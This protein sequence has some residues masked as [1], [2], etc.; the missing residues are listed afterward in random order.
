MR[1]SCETAPVKVNGTPLPDV[2]QGEIADPAI[3]ETVPTL[4]GKSV[5]DG[6]AIT[7]GPDSGTGKPQMVAVRRPLVPALPGRGARG[8]SSWPTQ[9]VFDGVDV[10]R[11]RHRD[12]RPGHQLPAVGVAE[13]EK[14]PFPVMADSPSCTAATGV[15]AQRSYPYFVLVNADGT[16]AGRAR[17]VARATEI[18]A[19]IEALEGAGKPTLP[20]MRAIGSPERAQPQL[21][22]RAAQ[23]QLSQTPTRSRRWCWVRKPVVRVIAAAAAATE[24]SSPADA[25]TSSTRPHVRADE[26]VVVTGE[27]LGELPA[28]ELVGADD[29][30][31]DAGF[32]EHHEVAVHRALREVGALVE[33]LGDRERARRA[34]VS[35][36]S[37]AWRLAVR[38]WPTA[39][40][41]AA[42]VSLHLLRRTVG[43]RADMVTS[44]PSGRYRRALDVTERF[45]ELIARPE[46]EIAL[47]EAAL[48][49]AAHAHPDLD[50]DAR[51]AQ[52]DALAAR[53]AGLLGRRAVRRMLFVTEGFRRQRRPTTATRATRSSTTCS[54]AISASRSR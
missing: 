49:I 9:G 35:V 7:I 16:V 50:V 4:T 5:Y 45:T 17:R 34:A 2:R 6:T 1:P 8:S 12:L 21:A 18:K 44:L 22:A 23:L 3:G 46:P 30:V 54:T 27:I 42:T 14:W 33:D 53:A 13:G 32:L 29:A 28:R 43:G 51:L 10:T 19:N 47:D 24:R 26:V 48:L 25:G 39:R 37:S 52:L 15:R 11:G 40:R 31:H 38:R 41:R 36:S 20:L